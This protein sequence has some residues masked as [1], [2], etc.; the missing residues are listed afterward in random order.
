MP[1]GNY[2]RILSFKKTAISNFQGS[3]PFLDNTNN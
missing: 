2:G 3:A 1:A